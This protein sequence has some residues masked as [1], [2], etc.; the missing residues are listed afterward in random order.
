MVILVFHEFT[1]TTIKQVKVFISNVR[2][3]PKTTAAADKVQ[4]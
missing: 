1:L 3:Q 2:I 4:L